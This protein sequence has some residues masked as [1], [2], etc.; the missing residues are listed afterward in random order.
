MKYTYKCDDCLVEWPG[1]NPDSCPNGHENFEIIGTQPPFGKIWKFSIAIVILAGILLLKPCGE[2]EKETGLNEY[3]IS[4][5]IDNPNYFVL[6]GIDKKN[7]EK[8]KLSMQNIVTT[9]YLFSEGNKFF[10]CEREGDYQIVIQEKMNNT[11]ET[12]V[13][14]RMQEG[15][16][17]H[18][19]ACYK[20]VKILDFKPNTEDC[21]Y[22]LSI[23]IERDEDGY[24]DVEVSFNRDLDFKK[25]KQIW[26]KEE[27]KGKLKIYVRIK[28]RN[29]LSDSLDIP[30]CSP[31]GPEV[32]ER[33]IA[34]SFI[35]WMNDPENM[36]KEQDFSSSIANDAVI[37]S[38]IDGRYRDIS[39]FST[40]I[41]K[42]S[43]NPILKRMSLVIS[44][45]NSKKIKI[46]TE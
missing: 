25:I 37:M 6:E 39:G 13:K 3:H 1:D 11:G 33:K 2:K 16:D 15:I 12:K 30:E 36:D 14:F 8:Y 44:T 7:I 17:P 41:Y 34:I 32:P 35:A 29:I 26:I 43:T 5:N 31:P 23:D 19:N 9:N 10:P 20:N 42:N 40:H 24:D 4:F 46:K 38:P 27:V 21:S 22:E 45:C 18:I 28:N